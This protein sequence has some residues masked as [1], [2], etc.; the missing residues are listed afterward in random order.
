M[1][2]LYVFLW[3]QSE[4][5]SEIRSHTSTVDGGAKVGKL[6]DQ[7]GKEASWDIKQVTPDSNRGWSFWG[8]PDNGGEQEPPNGGEGMG[9]FTPASFR[10]WRVAQE[11]DK[12]A[13]LFLLSSRFQESR[14]LIWPTSGLCCI[15][16]SWI[17]SKTI[18]CSS[19]VQ[20]HSSP[21]PNHIYG[22]KET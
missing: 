1:R 13:N 16:P 3:V 20:K 15:P 8:T 14:I 6:W 21:V 11:H 22:Q 9:V 19:E 4:A 5:D 12:L 18:K 10:E 17:W 7:E 2:F